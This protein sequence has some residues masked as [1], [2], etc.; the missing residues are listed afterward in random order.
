MKLYTQ[1]FIEVMNND[2]DGWP[3]WLYV[4]YEDIGAVAHNNSHVFGMKGE[5]E[6]FQSIP[7]NLLEVG[8]KY[9]LINSV[10]SCKEIQ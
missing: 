10:K 7:I 3:I 2:W 9:F 4:F 5:A 1:G 6:Q 8:Q